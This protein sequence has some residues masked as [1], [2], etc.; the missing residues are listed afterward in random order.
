MIRSFIQQKATVKD[1]MAS[2]WQKRESGE[3][4][5]SDERKTYDKNAERLK[6]LDRD[7]KERSEYL[8]SVQKEHT[9]EKTELARLEKRASLFNI[10]KADLFEATNK[11]SRFKIDPGPL[12][13][14]KQ[15]RT[16]IVPPEHLETGAFPIPLDEFGRGMQKRATVSTAAGSGQDLREETIFPEIVPNL[17]SKSWTG[18]AGVTFIEG[19]R[20]DFLLPAEDT[21]PASGFVAE[22]AEYAESSIDYKNAISLSALKVGALQPF[23]LQSFMQDE[24]RQLQNSISSQLMKEWARMVDMDFLYGNGANNRPNGIATLAGIQNLETGKG[25]NGDPL[26]FGKC[27]DAEGLFKNKDQDLPP[28]WLINSNTVTHAR[29]TLRNNVAGSLYIG[30]TQRLADRRFIETNIVKADLT[31]GT[32]TMLSAAHLIIPSSVVVVSWAMP[33]I[34]IDRS[35]GFK[36][37]TVWTKVSGY[38]NIGLKRQEDFVYLKNIKTD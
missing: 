8:E 13:E 12:N 9:P 1:V 23:S 7:I 20:G 27:I 36:S 11:D 38:V 10:L 19:W 18:R 31:K 17:Y 21:K 24:T 22:T 33:S 2:L 5:S 34:A 4:W 26:T 15:E 6:E 37:D 3:Q 14:I 32:S 30:T 28:L 35:I 16:K 25:A 29:Q